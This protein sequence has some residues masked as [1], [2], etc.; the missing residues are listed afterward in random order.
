MSDGRKEKTTGT[1][2]Y[3]RT[4]W[5]TVVVL[6]AMDLHPEHAEIVERAHQAG[7]M[8]TFRLW[9]LRRAGVLCLNDNDVA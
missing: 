5:F 9:Q 2:V 7:F 4:G 3:V 6:E 1:I 8:N